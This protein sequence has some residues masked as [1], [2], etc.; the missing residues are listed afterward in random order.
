MS[1]NAVAV[2]TALLSTF[3]TNPAP[4]RALEANSEQRQPVYVG[5]TP[6]DLELGLGRGPRELRLPEQLE[7]VGENQ[8][9]VVRRL[10]AKGHSEIGDAPVQLEAWPVRDDAGRLT[11]AIA[12]WRLSP[13]A[14]WRWVDVNPP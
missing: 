6:R 12:R 14:S 3:A 2:S 8:L 13:R 10:L 5:S 1:F 9:N 4:W 11:W 7:A